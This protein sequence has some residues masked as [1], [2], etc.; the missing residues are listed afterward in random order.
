MVR[1]KAALEDYDCRLIG[2]NCPGHHHA[3]RMQ[4]RASCPASSTARPR[5]VVSR[6]GTLTYEAVYQTTRNG[7][8]Q[9]TCVGIGGDPVRGMNFIDTLELFESDPQTEGHH[10]RRRDRRDRRRGAAR[11]HRGARQQ[12]G[13]RLHRG[14]H[15]AAGLSAWVTQAR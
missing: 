3:G 2:P 10:P 8:G 12:A 11:L 14:R 1:V 6:S 9:S 7:L 13:R 4:D 15:R 5:G